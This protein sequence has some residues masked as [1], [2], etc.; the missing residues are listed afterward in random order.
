MTELLL[1]VSNRLPV[2]VKASGDSVDVRPSVGGLATGLRG[3]HERRESLWIGW[4]GMEG[5]LAE[6]AERELQERLA[7]QRLVSVPMSA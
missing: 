3:L 6:P 7:A 4:S 1:V 5:P 2:T